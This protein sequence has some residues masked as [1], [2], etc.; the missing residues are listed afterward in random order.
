MT[1]KAKLSVT[2]IAIGVAML[3]GGVVGLASMVAKSP[4]KTEQEVRKDKNIIGDDIS[5]DDV[6]DSDD[7]KSK[8]AELVQDWQSAYGLDDCSGYN[9]IYIDDDDI[10]ELCMFRSL[11]SG[12]GVDVYTYVEGAGAMCFISELPS[13]GI[14]GHSL[15]YYEKSGY[16]LAKTDIGKE[17]LYFYKL[18]DDICLAEFNT[19]FDEKNASLVIESREEWG[20]DPAFTNV[21]Y[22]DNSGS[23]HRIEYDKKYKADDI[24]D[25]DLIKDATNIDDFDEAIDV[26]DSIMTYDEICDVLDITDRIVNMYDYDY[27]INHFNHLLSCYRDGY[28][29]NTSIG[30]PEIAWP[31]FALGDFNSDGYLDLIV[32]GDVVDKGYKCAEVSIWDGSSFNSQIIYGYPVIYSDNVI[33]N[34][35]S[36]VD[37]DNMTEEYLEEGYLVEADGEIVK[38]YYG[39]YYNEFNSET[40]DRKVLEEKYT[41]DGKIVTKDEYENISGDSKT[42]QELLEYT[43]ADSDI[44][45]DYFKKYGIDTISA[46]DAACYKKLLTDWK[47]GISYGYFYGAWDSYPSDDEEVKMFA[48]TDINGDN[49][50]ELLVGNDKYFNVMLPKDRWDEASL[51]TYTYTDGDGGLYQ[52]SEWIDYEE[53]SIFIYDGSSVE[54]IGT[55]ASFELDDNSGEYVYGILDRPTTEEDYNELLDSLYGLSDMEWYEVTEENINKVF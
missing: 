43:S 53:Y 17:W 3:I 42:N 27:L 32:V 41:V 5:N 18:R 33:W 2:F 54:Y 40:G 21:I 24:P 9:L 31:E 12:V 45:I 8:Y 38:K 15:L 52:D 47:N 11:Y 46:S 50:K 51:G 35:D 20:K 25:I 26:L 55:M 16:V 22:A 48:Y 28:Y 23:Y 19:Y 7:W 36:S 13:M 1:S 37:I 6:S 4:E 14:D 29:Q 30:S 49:V 44:V 39:Y 34:I 10:P